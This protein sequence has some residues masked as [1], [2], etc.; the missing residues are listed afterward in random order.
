MLAGHSWQEEPYTNA[1]RTIGSNPTSQWFGA[2]DQFGPNVSWD[3][4]L[5]SA[6][7]RSAVPGDYLYRTF[8][9]TD[10]LFGMWGVMRVSSPAPNCPTAAV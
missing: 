1:S 10:F 4:V 3:L 6:G 5:D 9:G 8:I 2:R 7:G